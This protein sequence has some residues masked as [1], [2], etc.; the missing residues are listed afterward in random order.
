MMSALTHLLRTGASAAA[1]VCRP[2]PYS[3]P[4]STGRAVPC[5]WDKPLAVTARPL[6]VA[7]LLDCFDLRREYRVLGVVRSQ[8]TA[9][10]SGACCVEA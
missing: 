3:Y 5:S 9:S 10:E 1:C 7:S 6:S 2:V 8:T 4:A